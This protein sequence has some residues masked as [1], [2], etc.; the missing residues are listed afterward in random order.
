MTIATISA[1]GGNIGSTTKH[2]YSANGG[3]IDFAPATPNA[4]TV[5]SYF[6]KGYAW[7]AN[8]GWIHFGSGPVNKLAYSMAGGDYGVNAEQNTGRLTGYAYAPSI[9]WINFGWAAFNDPNRAR[10]T[11]L[12]GT[13]G[14]YA[15]SPSVGWISLS[16]V[17]STDLAISDS[18]GDNI[19]DA[20][21][22]THFGNLTSAGI[23]TDWDGDGQTDAAEATASTN[24][25]DRTSSLKV[26]SYANA[27]GA[28][29]HTLTFTTVNT[30][31]YQ[32]WT[33]T[34]LAP[35]SWVIAPTTLA[36]T[37]EL[38]GSPSGTSTVTCNQPAAPLRFFRVTVRKY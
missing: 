30:R 19:D 16:G 3:S 21:E 23:G 13:F 31:Y 32:V 25:K 6:I 26:S 18:D 17:K 5:G 4:V 38:V 11:P 20:W 29:S 27:S 28:T 15:W 24:P 14:G 8:Y 1:K 37:T 2:G 7:S 34:T 35:G 36:G 33:S 12:S 9:G 22:M 10:Y